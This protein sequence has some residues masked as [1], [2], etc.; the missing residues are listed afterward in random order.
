MPKFIT[1]TFVLVKHASMEW[2]DLGVSRMGKVDP[3]LWTGK[4]RN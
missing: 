3:I 1:S 4:R 2:I